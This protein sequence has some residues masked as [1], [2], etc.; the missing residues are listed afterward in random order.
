LLQYKAALL[1][2]LMYVPAAQT[3][4]PSQMQAVEFE[5]GIFPKPQ[6]TAA[7]LPPE[8]AFPAGHVLHA[9]YNGA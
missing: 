9:P 7:E 1:A 3:V 6:G 8:Q 4:T 5:L 2:R